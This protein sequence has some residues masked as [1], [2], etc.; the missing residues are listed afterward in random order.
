MA[1][2]EK[3]AILLPTPLARRFVRYVLG[4]GLAIG[5]AVFP[6]LSKI[7]G[8]LFPESMQ[9][10][11]L[12]MSALSMGFIAVAV[13][14]Y[15]GETIDRSAVRRRFKTVLISLLIGL[16]LFSVLHG[17]LVVTISFPD[18]DGKILH[19]PFV[20]WLFRS[21][22][23]GCEKKTN[24]Q[25]CINELSL[26]E[27]KIETCWNTVP[28]R[29]LLQFSYLVLTGGLAALIGLLLLQEEAHRQEKTKAANKKA[30]RP[31]R[32]PPTPAKES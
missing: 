17:V 3:P 22:G 2:E 16:I 7:A 29:L 28:S 13:Q 24:D 21:E 20:I 10:T 23:C 27:K 14:F 32:A 5:A 31:R 30:S 12:I 9:K 6:F 1:R 15:S 26:D 19:F 25:Q 4:F 11:L 8:D 18:K